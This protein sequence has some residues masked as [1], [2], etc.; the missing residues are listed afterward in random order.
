MKKTE[1]FPIFR[2]TDKE[3]SEFEDVIV[4]E[5]TLT[6]FLNGRELVSLLCSPTELKELA[7][8][9]LF[10]E[11]LLQEKEEI[12]ELVVNQ[13]KGVVWVS[14]KE[15]KDFVK[16]LAFKKL[17]TS[18]GGKGVTFSNIVD[19]ANCRKV[20][21]QMKVLPQEVFDLVRK[22]QRQSLLFQSTGGV[23][24][25]ALCNPRD[26][27]IFSEDI[28]RHNALD[29]VFGQALLKGIKLKDKIVVTSGRIS[30]EILLKAGRHNLP[31][32]V[33]RSAPTNLAVKLAKR[34]GITL[35]GFVRGKRMNVYTGEGRVS[36]L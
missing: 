12:E 30:S 19:T 16:D 35:I 10:S 17:I 23:H 29:K 31:L 14:T 18:G 27:L 22:M 7:L 24:S 6:I 20:N 32:V 1:K 3:K 25:A 26:I 8:G 13:E 11:G 15:N 2:F 5:F 4:R 36:L 28:G 34:L 33:S 21:S 9:F